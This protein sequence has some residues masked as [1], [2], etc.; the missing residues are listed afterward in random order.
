MRLT[1][2][3]TTMNILISNVKRDNQT[4]H[5]SGQLNV[6][7]R[8]LMQEGSKHWLIG[9]RFLRRSGVFC[10]GDDEGI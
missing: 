2:D 10:R 8:T 9:P 7:S 4:A 6:P 3:A 5:I 1:N